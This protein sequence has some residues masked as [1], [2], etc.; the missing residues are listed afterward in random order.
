MSRRDLFESLLLSLSDAALDEERWPAASALVDELCGS[1]GNILLCAEGDGPNDFRHT[2]NRVCHRGERREDFERDYFRIY[3]SI[4]ER[5]PRLRRLPDSRI[6][7]IEELY[8]DEEKRT[9]IAYNEMLPM[10]DTADCLHARLDGP[11]GTRI[12]WT[13]GDPIDRQGWSSERVDMLARILPHLR[14]FMRVRLALAGADA[15]GATMAG[16]IENTRCG[17][18]QL[19]PRGRILEVNDRARRIL[20]QHDGLGDAAGTL[21]ARDPSED[22]TLRRIVAAALP[23]FGDPPASGSM[24]VSRVPDLPPRLVL[25]VIPAGRHLLDRPVGRVAAIALLVEPET[26]ISADPDLVADALGLTAAESRVAVMLADGHTLGDIAAMT[27]RSTRTVRWHLQQ[28]F[29]KNRI[30][31]QVEL[32]QLVRSL[33]LTTGRGP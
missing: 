28:I 33:S 1:K 27:G 7:G 25:H 3:H 5:V 23:R 17:I 12:L 13:T 20:R 14:Q 6:T 24:T 8:T 15:L 19:D 21:R 22:A 11:D 9:S 26:R 16:L 31:R 30:S 4:D 10:S 18:V 2:F 32:V 29:E